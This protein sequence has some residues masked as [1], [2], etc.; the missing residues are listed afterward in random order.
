M[1]GDPPRR[2]DDDSPEEDF[3]AHRAAE[4][5]RLQQ[6]AREQELRPLTDML[7]E[8]GMLPGDGEGWTGPVIWPDWWDEIPEPHGQCPS[9]QRP[10]VVTR[11][12]GGDPSRPAPCAECC[13]AADADPGQPAE[14]ARWASLTPA[15]RRAHIAASYFTD[16]W[17]G[18]HCVIY[19][20]STNVDSEGQIRTTY[21]PYFG[22]APN[23]I[24]WGARRRG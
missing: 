22:C 4:L 8:H 19:V 10:G 11:F 9:C 24:Y 13:A 2:W 1:T 15:A 6:W 5:D 12:F 3:E 14:L 16:P 21:P 20:E 7:E 17:S 23:G 18:R